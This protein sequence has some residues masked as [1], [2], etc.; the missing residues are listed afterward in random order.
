MRNLLYLFIITIL[1]TTS[2]KKPSSE[3]EGAFNQNKQ[4]VEVYTT[5]P[6]NEA[7]TIL[8]SFNG[9]VMVIQSVNRDDQY[10]YSLDGGKT[11]ANLNIDKEPLA[12][13]NQGYILNKDRYNN[14]IISR[15]DGKDAKISY[16]GSQNDFYFGKDNYIYNF[17]KSL[18]E[19]AVLKI[20]ENTWTTINNRADTLGIYC[21]QDQ[22]GGIAFQ[23]GDV[24][25]I[26]QPI[27]NTWEYHKMN[28][29]VYKV[30]NNTPNKSGIVHFNGY[31]KIVFGNTDLHAVYDLNTKEAQYYDYPDY[32]R[33]IYFN[34]IS[35]QINKQGDVYLNVATYYGISTLFKATN[36]I[37]KVIDNATYHYTSGDYSYEFT[38]LEAKKIGTSTENMDGLIKFK[39]FMINAYIT[40]DYVYSIYNLRTNYHYFNSDKSK[41]DYTLFT[42]NRATKTEKKININGSYNYVYA[43]GE[44]ILI[45]GGDS[46]TVSTDGGTSW[47]RRHSPLTGNIIDVKKSGSTYY[48][49]WL[50]ITSY[51]SNSGVTS[52]SYDFKMLTSSNLF[53][54]S[55]LPGATASGSG[56]GPQS[57]TT[58]GYLSAVQG[59]VSNTYFLEYS[60]DFGKTWTNTTEYSFPVFNTELGGGKFAMI[61]YSGPSGIEKTLLDERNKII[62]ITKYAVAPGKGFTL[63]R[64]PI[65][66]SSKK[67]YY[68]SY[69]EIY[70]LD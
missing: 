19:L 24:L 60:H 52:Y 33:N 29:N 18:K 65:V 47:T 59:F 20:E 62:N 53:T 41:S 44:N 34:P 42:Y 25:S 31:S 27:T 57:F 35:L 16:N 63:R 68:I 14:P 46:V 10:E 26:H 58:L 38:P 11:W 37:Y 36:G 55:Q 3:S 64:A 1:I 17:K 39:R 21:G 61:N 70:R 51:T 5:T 48:G 32:F 67:V 49:M 4:A 8:A 23:K 30:S 6:F 13:N 45:T 22:N 15:L 56:K 66:T 9:N 40:D 12:I 69:N 2:C 7:N 43:D 50:F 54:W 28:I